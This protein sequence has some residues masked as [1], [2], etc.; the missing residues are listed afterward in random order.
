MKY[1][2]LLLLFCIC[3]W[4]IKAQSTLRGS[5]SDSSSLLDFAQVYVQELDGRILNYTYSDSIGR[6]YLEFKTERDSILVYAARLGYKPYREVI[7]TE[8]QEINVQ[9]LLADEST[10]LE[11]V[12][13][14]RKPIEAKSDTLSYSVQPFSDGSEENAEDLLAKLPGVSVDKKSGAIRYQG[15]EI[16]KIL[17]DGDDLT[18]EN[19]KVLSKNL[20]ADWLETVEI[21]KRF[22]DSRLLQ[23]IQQSDEVA[24]NLKLKEEV[25]APLFGTSEIAGGNTSKYLVKAELLSYLKKLKLFALGQAN[26]TGADLQSYDLETYTNSQLEYKG[27]ILPQQIIDNLLS[28][29]SFLRQERFTFH[30]GQFFSN[31]MV[32]NLSSKTSLRSITTIYNNTINFNFSDSLFYLLPTGDGFSFAQQQIQNQKPFEIFQNLKTKS[33]LSVNQDLIIRF[34]IKSATDNPL[35]KNVTDF[36][37]Y[38][39]RTNLKMNE[40]FG[41][42]SYLKRLNTKWVN[43][44]DIEVGENS[45]DEFFVVSVENSQND[46][47]RQQTTQDVLN[48]GV[49]NR[50]D[51]VVREGLFINILSGWSHNNTEFN[52]MDRKLSNDSQLTNTYGFNHLFTEFKIERQIKKTKLSIGGRVRNATVKFNAEKSNDIYFEPTISLSTKKYLGELKSELKGLYNIEYVFLKPNQLIRSSLLSNYRSTI[53]YNS[54]P[55]IPI[56]NVIGVASINLIDDNISFLSANAEWV[57]LKSSSILASQ[58]MFDGEAVFNNQLQGGFSD[59]F[60][61]TYSLDKYFA[62]LKSTI[63]VA[64]DF[65]LSKTP[66]TLENQ[67]DKSKLSQKILS[68]TSGSSLTK[69]INLS[70]AFKSNQSRNRWNGHGSAFSFHNY[71]MKIV[72]KP[73]KALRLS[74]DYQTI[75]FRQS[76]DFSSILNASMFYSILDDKLSVEL[77]GNNL[78]NKKAIELSTIEPSVFSSSLYPLQPMFILVSANYRF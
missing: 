8:Q 37:T 66:L 36:S 19:Y 75:N 51:G 32:A 44:L 50:L 52:V 53:S 62:I 45:D 55:N 76:N 35:T 39:D 13:T 12:V 40:W 58:V 28:A 6:F 59:N 30:E 61:S 21:L 1:G 69:Q 7:S 64:Y 73:M 57:Y 74:F 65:N 49:F 15:K 78:T 31:S 72:I 47:I 3:F 24:I 46:S 70:L 56:R 14:E 17:L 10:L 22:T 27:F 20:S 77:T 33:Q 43:T 25:K 18:G 54:T 23:G 41:G 48:I 38:H 63:K 60:F 42:V 71:F 4:Q 67:L 34:Q 26:N 11:V 16:K 5:V 68:I 9:L 2:F 29:P